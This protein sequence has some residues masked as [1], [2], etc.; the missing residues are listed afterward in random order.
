LKGVFTT[1]PVLA[2]PNLDKKFRVE[3][4]ASNYMTGGVLSM[5]CFDNMWRPVIRKL[6]S[7]PE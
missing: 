4:N 6:N 2:A 3:A 1:K 7:K 5:K